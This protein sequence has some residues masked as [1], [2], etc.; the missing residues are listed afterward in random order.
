[1]THDHHD[2][3]PR[4]TQTEGQTDV[5]PLAEESLVVG[6]QDVVTGRVRVRTQT[7]ETQEIASL[8]LASEDADVVRVP[9][10][11]EVDAAPPVRTENDVTIVPILEEVMVVEKRLVLKEELHIRRRTSVESFEEPVT[12]RRQEAVVERE[13][14]TGVAVGKRP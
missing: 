12:L 11:R 9:I 7:K 14:A 5:L 1:M 3:A 2:P 10:G 4:A 6:K 13:D 8:D